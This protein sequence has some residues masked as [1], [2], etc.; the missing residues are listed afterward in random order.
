M[1][2]WKTWVAGIIVYCV[3]AGVDFLISP[4]IN[5]TQTMIDIGFGLLISVIVGVVGFNVICPLSKN[6]TMVNRFTVVIALFVYSVAVL[7]AIFML[8]HEFSLK[9]F[10]LKGVLVGVIA[11][12][13]IYGIAQLIH[14]AIKG[15]RL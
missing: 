2:S 3:I 11:M 6:T 10:L 4:Y 8:L 14:W 5:I 15:T 13:I 1:K 12:G 9:L 7:A